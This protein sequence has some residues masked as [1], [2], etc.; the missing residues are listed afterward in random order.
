MIQTRTD[1]QIPSHPSGDHGHYVQ[2]VGQPSLGP[3][4][5]TRLPP[6]D[7]SHEHQPEVSFH[8][9][10]KASSLL[11]LALA[12]RPGPVHAVIHFRHLSL[13]SSPLPLSL[14]LMV[15]SSLPLL[16]DHPFQAM[17]RGTLILYNWDMIQVVVHHISLS[18]FDT[19]HQLSHLGGTY[20]MTSCSRSVEFLPL[21]TCW[22][23]FFLIIK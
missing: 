16:I 11:V 13:I 7:S 23:R 18:Y 20:R 21:P 5:S 3:F 4:L 19:A 9:S 15:S 12:V 1:P 10:S 6:H 22:F 8:Y 17:S 2:V 14:H